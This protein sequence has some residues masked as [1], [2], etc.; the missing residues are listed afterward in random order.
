MFRSAARRGGARA[1]VRVRGAA[2]AFLRVRTRV[3]KRRALGSSP[4]PPD[5]SPH[6]RRR[7]SAPSVRGSVERGLAPPTRKSR[8][9]RRRGRRVGHGGALAEAGVA[10]GRAPARRRRPRTR[11]LREPPQRPRAGA[12]RPLGL[13]L[14]PTHGHAARQ[15]PAA[16]P[17]VAHARFPPPRF[18]A[19]DT[20]YSA[21]W[22]KSGAN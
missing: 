12:A 11:G 8:L 4:S 16:A 5:S 10:R 1:C 19:Y 7:S 14:I 2:R 3:S 15:S 9:A 6:Q 17:A 20:R 21:R 22:N 18:C 13:E